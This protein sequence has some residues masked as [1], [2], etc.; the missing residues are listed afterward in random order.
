M[1]DVVYLLLAD[2]PSKD[3][4]LMRQYYVGI[5]RA[6]NRLFV[7]TNGD[8]FANLPADRHLLDFTEYA[9][10]GEIVLQLTHRDVYLDFFKG[11]KR[12][13]LALRSGDA[14]HYDDTRLYNPATHQPVAILSADMQKKLAAW[15]EQGYTVASASVRFVV[16]WKP[17]DAPKD[18]PESAIVL[19]DLTL[20]KRL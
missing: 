10:P 12:E 20:S 13:V 18:A 4:D 11:V 14:L 2:R 6:K 8:S 17:K 1:F 3:T 15:E 9:M 19:A 7:H 16:A 5:T